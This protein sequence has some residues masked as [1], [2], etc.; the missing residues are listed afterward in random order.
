MSCLLLTFA[1]NP[2]GENVLQ[3]DIRSPAAI[4]IDF[5]TGEVLFEQNSNEPR[6]PASMTKSMTAFIVY[7]EIARGNLTLDTLVPI[8]ENAA[9]ISTG[10]RYQGI[11]FPLNAGAE[12]TVDTL[13][14]LTMVVS[15]NAAPVALAEFISGTEE[16]FVEKMNE[17]A[18]ELGMWSEFQNA[19]GAVDGIGHLTDAYSMA[20]LVYEFIHRYPDILRITSRGSFEFQGSTVYNTN[21][22]LRTR[23]LRGAD[24]FKTGTTIAAGR[25]LSSTAY[26]DGSRVI[27]VQMGAPS[28]QS[29]YDDSYALLE[30]GFL[31]VSRRDAFAALPE[32]KRLELLRLEQQWQEAL[33]QEVLASRIRLIFVRNLC[34]GH[35]AAGSYACR[36][37]HPDGAICFPRILFG[38]YI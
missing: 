31:E 18:R 7:E 36:A 29:R 20:R 8:S 25:N 28:Q 35:N 24:G 11:R 9:R 13:L 37:H 16:A 32:Q 3:P 12:H 1:L 17:T 2:L 6:H 27:A 10:A 21:L 22:L 5:D 4:V 14:H 23:P 34:G 19:H 26:R 38:K 15:S 33:R 30:F